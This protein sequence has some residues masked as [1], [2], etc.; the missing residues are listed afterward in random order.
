MGRCCRGE[1]GSTIAEMA[2][3]LPIMLAVLTGVFSFGVALNQ[4]LVLTNAVNNASQRLRDERA[5]QRSRDI[6]HE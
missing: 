6:R 1:E 5:V 2:L 4:Y 3:V